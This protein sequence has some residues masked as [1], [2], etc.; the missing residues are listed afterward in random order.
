MFI[1]YFVPTKHLHNTAIIKS[2]R[3]II[4][5]RYK[6]DDD[7]DDSDDECTRL[8]SECVS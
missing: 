8:P 3:A 6:Y 1:L 7:D 2:H 5:V 4:H